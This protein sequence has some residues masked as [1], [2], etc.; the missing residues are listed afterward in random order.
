MTRTKDFARLGEQINAVDFDHVFYIDDGTLTPAARTLV[1][2]NHTAPDVELDP[3]RD[4]TVSGKWSAITGMTGQ[5][6]YR[7]AVMHPS[8]F[9]GAGIAQVLAE[10]Y[11]AGTLFA[12]VEVRD[13]DGSF[14]DGDPIGWAIV[15]RKI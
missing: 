4:V 14:P 10:D 12:V 11:P 15:Y 3:S 7:G 6:G 2:T 13:E 5:H 8:E 9:I 1:T